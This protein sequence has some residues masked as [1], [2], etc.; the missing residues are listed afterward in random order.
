MPLWAKHQSDTVSSLMSHRM[1]ELCV[2]CCSVLFQHN[3]IFDIVLSS[4]PFQCVHQRSGS[5]KV[6]LLVTPEYFH[7]SN[8]VIRYHTE[9][10]D[11]ICCCTD[12]MKTGVCVCVHVCIC[13]VQVGKM[14]L[15][16]ENTVHWIYQNVQNKW[17]VY[18]WKNVIS[19]S[20]K[21]LHFKFNTNTDF[22]ISYSYL[23]ISR[24]ITNRLK[25]DTLWRTPIIYH[26]HQTA[27]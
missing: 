22:N 19:N 24:L 23:E 5:I 21:A 2:F 11:I 14:D 27:L 17:K 9:F 26:H 25:V 12:I 1:K 18:T 6:S 16:T 8:I 7:G 4:L 13:D 3:L 15:W 20:H 10:A